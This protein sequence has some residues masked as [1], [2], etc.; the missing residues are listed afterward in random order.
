[1]VASI[2][3]HERD[4]NGPM[5]VVGAS[6]VGGELVARSLWSTFFMMLATLNFFLA[7]FNLIPLPPFDGGHIAVIF[8]EKIRD[9]IRR[10]MGK[11]RKDQPITLR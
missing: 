5:F 7:L 2:F 8:Y 11:G 4:V 1:M 3:G 10:L 9:G 6:R